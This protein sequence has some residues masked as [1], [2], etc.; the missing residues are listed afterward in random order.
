MDGLEKYYYRGE[1]N[2]AKALEYIKTIVPKIKGEFV[3]YTAENINDDEEEIGRNFVSFNR[4]DEFTILEKMLYQSFGNDITIVLDNTL[5]KVEEYE[6]GVVRQKHY[7]LGNQI[8]ATTLCDEFGKEIA[9]YAIFEGE[10]LVLTFKDFDLYLESIKIEIINHS[11]SLEMQNRVLETKKQINELI[12][13]FREDFLKKVFFLEKS[14]IEKSLKKKV[15]KFDDKKFKETLLMILAEYLRINNL[16]ENFSNNWSISSIL[17]D[18][19]YFYRIIEL[20]SIEIYKGL[21]IQGNQYRAINIQTNSSGRK[22]FRVFREEDLFD[23]ATQECENI[24]MYLQ[25]LSK[26][27]KIDESD[28]APEKDDLNSQK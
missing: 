22:E 3:G 24:I 27:F 4:K 26:D 16:P 17:I 20:G 10:P 6:E 18:D 28:E 25:N 11:E 5:I 14:L 7:L 1:T 13:G 19:I 9:Y 2:L 15:N 8:V 23:E 12:E 21:D